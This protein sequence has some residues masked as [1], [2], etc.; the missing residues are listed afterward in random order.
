MLHHLLAAYVDYMLQ[1]HQEAYRVANGARGGGGGGRGED[2]AT[3]RATEAKSSD[4]S[5]LST[6]PD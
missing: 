6:A 5:G 1:Q 3:S 4:A 2:A